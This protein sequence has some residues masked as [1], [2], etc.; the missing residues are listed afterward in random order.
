MYIKEAT[1]N[2]KSFSDTSA[3]LSLERLTNKQFEQFKEQPRQNKLLEL[4]E[5][6][7]IRSILS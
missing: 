3:H 7:S 5:F 1:H 6:F 4:F 2:Y